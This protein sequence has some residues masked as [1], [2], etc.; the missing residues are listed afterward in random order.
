MATAGK[1]DPPSA[2][3]RPKRADVRARI[4]GAAR[5]AFV[6]EGYQRTNLGDIAASA[7]FSKGAVYSNFGGKADLFTA[8]I[9]EHTAI[10]INTALSSSER[11]VAAVTDP[12]AI[13]EV[14][15]DV[16]GIIVANAP[17][18]TMLT[19]FRSLAAGHPELAAVYARLRTEQRHN[20]LTDLRRRTAGTAVTI[21]EADAV[22]ILSLVQSLSAEHAIAPDAMPGELIKKTVRAAI[23][24]ILQ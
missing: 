9:N 12:A 5:A 19:E 10:L 11:L 13:D 18:L 7:G 6:R 20:L 22:L 1:V 23:K 3:P 2:Q 17:A 15:E 4:L 24:G 21:D 16:A 14:A 8:V